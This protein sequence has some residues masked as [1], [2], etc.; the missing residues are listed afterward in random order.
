MRKSSAVFELTDGEIRVFHFSVPPSFWKSG[1]RCTGVKFDRI[2]ISTGII[3]QGTVR[4]E[5][6][7]IDILSTYRSKNSGNYQKVYLAISLQQGFIQAYTLPWLPK[8]D[9]KSA[10]SLLVDEEISIARLDLLYDYLVISEEKHKN[11]RVLL[12]AARRSLLEQY[13]FIFGQAGFEIFEM[14]FTFS[15]LGQALGFEAN[16][17]VLYLQEESESLQLVLFRGIVPE[18]IRT[19]SPRPSKSELEE[20][21]SVQIEAWEN[22]INRVLLYYRTQYQDLNLNRLI[23][24]GN[25][26]VVKLAQRISASD[27]LT[28]KQAKLKDIPD[29]WQKVIEDNSGCGEMAVGYALRISTRR[30]RLNLWRQPTSEQKGQQTYL[31]LAVFAVF[32][33]VLE[34]LIGFSLSRMALPLRQEVNQLSDQGIKVQDQNQS[35]KALTTAW[36]KVSVHSEEIGERLAEVHGLA[37]TG[38]NIE[39]VVFKQGS[40][41]VRGSSVEAKSVQD[42]IQD[43]RVLGWEEPA[44]TSYKVTELNNVEFAL[45]AKYGRIGNEGGSEGTV[46]S[47]P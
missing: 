31:R 19:L 43:L 20:S 2:P 30:P 18:N 17:D 7:L 32:L 29:S 5:N 3:E 38:L 9:R 44:L 22:E 15:I 40:L 33:L 21:L 16:E 45:S 28:I 13:V 1:H 12:G 36:N 41:T 35:Q 39:Q 27:Q 6:T 24:S 42:M 25:Y 46:L 11:L 14:D 26:A 23:W 37:R 10:M 8:R 4:D 34:I 47:L